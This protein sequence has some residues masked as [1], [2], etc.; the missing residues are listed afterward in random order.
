MGSDGYGPPPWPRGNPVGP[1]DR[2]EPQPTGPS[3]WGPGP[4]SNSPGGV[5]P[6]QAGPDHARREYTGS[7]RTAPDGSEPE[8]GFGR[9]DGGWRPE[10]GD[11]G[12]E[13]A[14]PEDGG[15]PWFGTGEDEPPPPRRRRGIR[16]L[17]TALGMLCSL[18]VFAAVGVS[19]MLNHYERQVPRIANAFPTVP[20]SQRP[21]QG[22]GLNFLLVGLDTRSDLPTTGH[23]AKT[24]DWKPGAQRTDTMMVVHIDGDFQHV[25]VMSIPRDTW[26]PIP[27]HDHGKINAAFSFGGPPLLIQT[28]ENYTGIRIDHLMTVDWDGFK[29]LTDALG[30][31]TV[32]VSQDSYDTANHVQWTAGTHTLDGTQALL[33]VRQ[34]Y[35]LPNGDLDREARQQNFL[36]AVLEKLLAQGTFGSLSK[37]NS[38]L[39]ALTDTVQF[40]DQLSNEDLTSLAIDLRGLHGG[41]V[42]FL[43][44]PVHAYPVI[45]NQSTVQLDPTEAPVLFRDIE[46]DKVADYLNEYGGH[47]LAAPNQVN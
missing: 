10:A 7:G 3:I 30:G 36:R 19:W 44:P 1:G 23:D 13:G 17:F 2:P 4:D 25:Y 6:S 14:P 28:V 20:D 26:V 16:V 29:S 34:R 41:D 27:G 40:D 39:N 38:V 8:H 5:G 15:Q 18:A 47:Q 12:T 33:Y 11:D 35:G 45:D 37:T 9:G 31:V 21:Q 32:T 42:T 22:G 46:S 24:G 43:T